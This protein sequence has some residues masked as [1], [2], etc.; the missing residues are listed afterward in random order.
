M[1]N[2]YQSF[3]INLGIKIWN[4]LPCHLT[5]VTSLCQFKAKLFQFLFEKCYQLILSGNLNLNCIIW[6]IIWVHFF[7]ALFPPQ[8]YVTFLKICSIGLFSRIWNESVPFYYINFII[9]LLYELACKNKNHIS[10]IL[11]SFIIL[12]LFV[13][14]ESINLVF[15]LVFI[16]Y[17]LLSVR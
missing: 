14:V 12:V 10:R 1:T 15:E 11:K 8:S 2:M 3:T 13:N 5:E 17:K 9:N 7:P 6:L 16:S 4:R